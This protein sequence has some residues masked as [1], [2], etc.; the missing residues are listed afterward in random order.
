M[1]DGRTHGPAA[2]KVVNGSRC[3]GALSPAGSMMARPRLALAPPYT[4]GFSFIL[5]EDHLSRPRLPHTSGRE[6]E[7][8]LIANLAAGGGEGPPAI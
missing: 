2:A 7:R 5:R 6:D 1:H 3:Q 4:A 8:R